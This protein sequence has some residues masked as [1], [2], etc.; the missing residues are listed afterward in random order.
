VQTG[1][2]TNPL[3][4]AM[5]SALTVLSQHCCAQAVLDSN[6]AT[7]LQPNQKHYLI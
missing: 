2:Q 5:V 3:H 4:L 1:L 7:G 6:K